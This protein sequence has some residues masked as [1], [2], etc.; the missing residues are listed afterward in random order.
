MPGNRSRPESVYS[1]DGRPNRSFHALWERPSG[2]SAASRVLRVPRPRL[3]STSGRD[4]RVAGADRCVRSACPVRWRY[5]PVPEGLPDAHLPSAALLVALRSPLA[6]CRRAEEVVRRPARRGPAAAP[7][8]ELRRGPGRVRGGWPR[9]T[10]SSPPAAPIGISQT[11]RQVGEY[12]KALAVLTDA[13]KAAADHPDLLAARADLLFDLGRWDEAVQG[14]RRGHQEEGRPPPRPVGEGPAPP[15]PGRARR[16][17]RGECAGSSALHR[18]Q[19]RRQRHHRPG[20][21]APR[22]PGRGRERPLAQPGR[23]SS[24]SSSTRSSPTPSR[25]TRTS[26]RPSTSPGDAPGEVQPAGRRRG[27]RQG[28]EDQPEG[29]RRRWSARGWRRSRSST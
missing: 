1:H 2:R 11:Y 9:R 5:D 10:R 4:G 16:G 23:A 27:L 12:D 29:G 19:Q 26:G 24:G 18:P 14:R 13:L 22:R 15:R 6:A 8:G 28:A 17:R 3:C 25:S 20:R 21:A 7:E